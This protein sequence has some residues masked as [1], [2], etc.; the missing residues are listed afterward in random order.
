MQRR[1]VAVCVE[2]C[3]PPPALV[4]AF[5]GLPVTAP[6]TFE[7]RVPVGTVF[8]LLHAAPREV[9]VPAAARALGCGHET[10]VTHRF[11]RVPFLSC[12]AGID[13]H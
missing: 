8:A 1:L 4:R 5:H 10:I 12:A 13:A 11:H 2:V 6:G 9:Q 7:L 3:H